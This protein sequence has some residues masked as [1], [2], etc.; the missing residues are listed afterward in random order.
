MHAKILQEREVM[1][2]ACFVHSRDCLCVISCASMHRSI[3]FVVL[4]QYTIEQ[5]STSLKL[6]FIVAC[7]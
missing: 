3:Q 7:N 4:A 1:F 5:A 6:L 2:Y